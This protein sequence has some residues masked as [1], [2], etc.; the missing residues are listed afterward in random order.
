MWTLDERWHLHPCALGEPLGQALLA[1]VNAEYGLATFH[2]QSRTS[3]ILGDPTLRFF[4]TAP[5][6]DLSAAKVGSTVNLSWNAPPGSPM[7]F[8]VYRATEMEGIFSAPLNSAPLLNTGFQDVGAPAGN[9]VYQVRAAERIVSGSGSFTNLS[10]G[11][12][13]T[14]N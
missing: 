4:V 11:V 12:F 6:R 13:I 9:K 1:T 5:P 10:Q 14:I 3:A 7:T 2:P 8:Y